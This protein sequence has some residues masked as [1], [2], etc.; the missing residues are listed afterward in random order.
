MNYHSEEVKGLKINTAKAI[1]EADKAKANYKAAQE[2]L[3]ANASKI[4]EF[5]KN[6]LENIARNITNSLCDY[7]GIPFVQAG[8]VRWGTVTT[9]GSRLNIRSYPSLS[10]K[11][12]GSLPNGASVTINGKTGDWYVV[13]YNG[14][15]GYSSGRFITI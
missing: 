8:A 14:I 7:F 11:I 1:D 2:T 3:T 13:S 15:V 10:G 4:E 9:D 12:I 6:N 5:K